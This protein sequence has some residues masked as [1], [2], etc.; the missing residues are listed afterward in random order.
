MSSAIVA[1]Q[2]HAQAFG[3]AAQPA[4]ATAIV[5]SSCTD[6]VSSRPSAIA[7]TASPTTVRAS[8]A[9]AIL[10]G[11]MSALERMRMEQTQAATSVAVAA[12]TLPIE[13]LQPAASG[14]RYCA[15]TAAI[16]ALESASLGLRPGSADDFLASKRV[17]IGKTS[18]DKEW[19]RVRSET[20]SKRAHPIAAQAPAASEELV[21]T[22]NRWVN[23]KIRY[24]EDRELFGRADY[25]A[26]AQ[27]TLT[28]G[29][30]DCEDIALAK[31]QLLAAA[32]IPR[33]DMY[34]TIARDA[35]RRA[36]HALLIVKLDGRY[37]VLDNATDMLLDGAYSNDYRPVLS[38]SGEQAWIHGY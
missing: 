18:F 11:E 4:I 17:R 29:Q 27:L 34:L 26:G 28:L 1:A 3:I 13:P 5:Q 19:R 15:S 2:A 25:W 35:V 21:A 37:V 14:N 31:M 20:L 12:P 22:I 23:Q 8:K 38:F 24:V 36:D 30:G 32:G 10:G 9:A 33:S 16:P 6:L 7:Q